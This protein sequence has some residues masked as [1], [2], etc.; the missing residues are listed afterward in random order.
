[1]TDKNQ[2]KSDPPSQ[3]INARGIPAAPFVDKIEE[4]VASAEHVEGT[5][6]SFQEMISKYQFMELNTQRR[7]ASLKEKLPEM[8]KSL[9]TVRFLSSHTE[10]SPPL[11]ATFSL[12]DTLYAHANIPPTSEVYLWL[13]A[14]IM[15]SYPIP[16]AEELLESKLQ[17]A[18]KA[19]ESCEEDL[20][21]LREQITTLEV[22]TAR[23]YNW[24]VTRK[25]KE[26]ETKERE[27]LKE[28]G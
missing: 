15:L 28:K 9:D 10:P 20:D 1:M 7:V 13:G 17:A 2:S 4:Y 11:K 8:Q 26:R 19:L 21:Y 22:A 5:L 6:K 16:E 24:D 23:V 18:K 12:S 27:G 14:N 25:R 3:S